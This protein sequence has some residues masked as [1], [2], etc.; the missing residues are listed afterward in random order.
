VAPVLSL[1]E[2]MEHPHLKA[3]HTYVEH[4][5]LRQAAPAPRF[6]RTPGAIR[7]SS[8]AAAMLEKWRRTGRVIK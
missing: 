4:E 1:E 3:R 6:S 7:G 5:G 8:A 2:A